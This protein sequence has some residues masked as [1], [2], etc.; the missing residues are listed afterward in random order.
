[1]QERAAQAQA[2]HRRHHFLADQAALAHA[3]Y[4]ELAAELVD[5]LD[6]FYR[7]QQAVPRDVV[8]LIQYCDLGE[9]GGGGRQD[10]HGAGE[11][12]RASGVVLGERRRQRHGAGAFS[13]ECA[14]GWCGT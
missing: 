9:G 14:R 11:D 5:T 4:Y 3:A 12:V 6:A 13:L 8:A 2:L 1:M 7:L 10:V